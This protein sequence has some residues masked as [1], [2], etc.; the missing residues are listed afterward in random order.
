MESTPIPN[1]MSSIT[2][3]SSLVTPYRYFIGLKL[4]EVI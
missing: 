1:I 2:L 3:F 4:T